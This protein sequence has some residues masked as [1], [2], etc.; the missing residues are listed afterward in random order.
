MHFSITS[1]IFNALLKRLVSLTSIDKESKVI[2]LLENNKLEIFY[3]SKVDKIDTISLFYENLPVE[4]CK[5]SGIAA[6]SASS[7][8]SIKVP[9]TSFIDKYPK[10]TNIDFSFS[11]SIMNIKYGIHWTKD[12]KENTTKLSFPLLESNT[13]SLDEFDSICNEDLSSIFKVNAVVLNEA[14][15]SVNFI[16]TDATSKD[17]HGCLFF[18]HDSN[19]LLVNTDSNSAV[20][21]EFPVEKLNNK[22]IQCTL[23]NTVLNAIKIFLPDEGSV[24]IGKIRNHLFLQT[25]TRRMLVPTMDVGYAIDDPIEFFT[26]DST[27]VSEVDLKPLISVCLA[28]VSKTNDSYKRLSF[29][30][31]NNGF[32][33]KSGGDASVGLPHQYHSDAKADVNGALFT[34]CAQRLLPLNLKANFYYNSDNTRITLTSPD[35]KMICLI[36]GLA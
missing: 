28:L 35:Y 19:F 6:I 27:L 31:D 3:N 23:S 20:K 25:D 14:I 15:S 22:G 9:E 18:T 33:I 30:I 26:I 36:Q 24:E 1:S 7:L 13:Y 17:A 11:K 10:T 12:S 29:L 32:A 4:S 16:K 34:A 21:Y 5:G 2:F 8:L